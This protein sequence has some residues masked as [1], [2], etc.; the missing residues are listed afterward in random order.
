MIQSYKNTWLMFYSITD[1]N[2]KALIKYH[3]GVFWLGSK[4]VGAY[5]WNP[6]KITEKS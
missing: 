5:Q 2:I 6:Q 4:T 3:H 1:D